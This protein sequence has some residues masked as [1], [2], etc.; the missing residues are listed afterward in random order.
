MSPLL[1][2]YVEYVSSDFLLSLYVL[3]VRDRV[4]PIYFQPESFFICF[5]GLIRLILKSTQLNPS[6]APLINFFSGFPTAPLLS[7]QKGSIV[8]TDKV[9]IVYISMNINVDKNKCQSMQNKLSSLCQ[10]SNRV[11]L[12]AGPIDETLR[13]AKID[14]AITKSQVR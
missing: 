14:A 8:I 13:N 2:C 12:Y 10:D 5:D 7:R 3:S 11:C 6:W 9:T 4:L 1:V